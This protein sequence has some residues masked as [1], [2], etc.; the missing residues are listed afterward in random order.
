MN[1]SNSSRKRVNDLEVQIREAVCE[2]EDFLETRCQSD[3]QES[4]DAEYP[5][6]PFPIELREVEIYINPFI[7]LVKKLKQEYMNELVDPLPEEEDDI[8]SSREFLCKNKSRM[9][10]LYDEV[11]KIKNRFT[12]RRFAL[13]IVPLAG[14]AGIGKTTVAKHVFQDPSLLKCFD[15]RAWVEV[16]PNYKLKDIVQSIVAQ[17][18]RDNIDELTLTG[19]RLENYMHRS[20]K[21]KRYL[22]VL[23]DV[24]ER[25]V[26]VD[27]KRIFPDDNNKSVV[28]LTTRL[29]RVASGG[30]MHEMRFL[31]KEESWDL[32]REKVFDEES[33]CP[34]LLEK[35]GKKIAES[36]EGLPLT[37]VT[38]GELLSKVEKTPQNW[39]E[40]AKNPNRLLA[41][42][43]DQML[44]VL[45]PS[46]YYLPQ[47]LKA[48]FLFMGVF[49]RNHEI[50]RSELIMLWTVDTLF[51]PSL[52]NYGIFTVC[53]DL[54]ESH[55]LKPGRKSLLH[56]NKTWSLHSSFWHLCRREASKNKFFHVMESFGDISSPGIE[57]QRRLCVHNNVLLS[58][59]DVH[60]K[61]ASIS[62]IRSLLFTG[63]PHQY[64]VP[65]CF[66]FSLLRILKAITIRL[67]EF[68][69]EVLKL[70]EL[71]YLSLTCL[72]NL[73]TSI[74][75]LR[76][77]QFIIIRR[78]LSICTDGALSYLPKEIWDMKELKHLQIMGSDLPDPG[79]GSFLPNLKTLLDIS[80]R[81]CT[82]SVFQGLP[83]LEKLGI[84][85][86]VAPDDYES[87]HCF[88]HINFLKKLESLK[89]VVV[90]PT[91]SYQVIK[92]PHS[93]SMVNFPPSL[94]KLSLSGFGYPWE[95]TRVIASLPN[96]R[97]LKLRCYAFRGPKWEIE[98]NGF[99][100]LDILMIEDTDLVHWTVGRGSM[101]HLG[102]VIL[103]S[104]YKLE[105]LARADVV[106]SIDLVDCN[107]LA[108]TCAQQMEWYTIR[109][110][111]SPF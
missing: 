23:D 83:E 77:I 5:P 110:N 69:V 62:T 76:N 28:L 102:N 74:S 33:S 64:P 13:K 44:K 12:E 51:H 27:I 85:I 36:C 111:I 25:S 52:G 88:D 1:R 16:G 35:I 41:E 71:R 40:L 34:P 55:I 84:R 70:V 108:V 91:F 53:I 75:K 42:A 6:S 26:W 72:G 2:L 49:P 61:M 17:V 97:A 32:L 31:S 81:S 101:P 87:F 4:I 80:A 11:D 39:T 47:Y 29:C 67:Y 73:P 107:P 48:C 93:F 89:C 18:N 104:C 59:K 66:G 60:K 10:G 78:H 79:D 68:P 14:M 106:R 22:I 24:W 7:Q 9:V 30:F 94:R 99:P 8:L 43:Y 63:Q 65:L 3:D 58:I 20:L 86:E 100:R 98:D 109:S 45:L 21:R 54:V 38:V 15:V 82:S 96:L 95:D 57:G 46:Y 19:E 50:T 105:K 90:N 56:I 92:T 37:I 103:K